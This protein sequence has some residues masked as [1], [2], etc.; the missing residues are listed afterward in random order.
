MNFPEMKNILYLFLKIYCRIALRVYFSPLQIHFQSPVPKGPVLFVA[1]HQNAFL[2]AVLVACCSH[3]NPWFLARANVFNKPWAAKVL[4]LLKMMPIYRFRDG[5]GT[6][7]KND[8]VIERCAELLAKGEAILIFAEGNHDDRWALRPF[9]KGFAR[10]ALA[11]R[12]KIESI[13][14]VPVGLQYDSHNSFRS[15]VLVSFG[16]PVRVDANSTIESLVTETAQRLKPLILTIDY[17]EYTSCANYLH[18]KRSLQ[19]NLIAQLRLDQQIVDQYAGEKIFDTATKKKSIPWWNPLF[20]YG[21]ANHFLAWKI[22]QW[23][24]NTKVKDSQFIGSIKFAVGMVLVPLFYLLQVEFL[25]LF[26]H[27]FWLVLIY[28]V[29]LV[30]SG[31]LAHLLFVKSN[32]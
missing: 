17:S 19:K 16:E 22:L 11:A 10:M 32:S 27:S 30:P 25:Y 31:L 26:S 18:A 9:Q 28:S 14:I 15:R 29:T 4:A 8:E 21:F 23:V 20:I 1:N 2:D 5:F 3:R 6:L 12:E 7:R 13:Q 24:L